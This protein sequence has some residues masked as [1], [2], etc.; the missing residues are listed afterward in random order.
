MKYTISATMRS[1]Q[2]GTPAAAEVKRQLANGPLHE[3][4]VIDTA[5]RGALKMYL[6]EIEPENLFGVLTGLTGT[7]EE[8][9]AV[10]IDQAQ[11]HGEDSILGEYYKVDIT[12]IDESGNF[13]GTI[14][15]GM[16]VP[17]V[18]DT[19]PAMQDIPAA[20]VTAPATSVEAFEKYKLPNDI[21][22]MLG[23]I[24]ADGRATVQDMVDR[25]EY[26]SIQKWGKN[27]L[28]KN[29]LA[30]RKIFG[31]P[32][33]CNHNE[34]CEKPKKLWVDI[35]EYKENQIG[36]IGQGL[37]AAL[38]GYGVML[39][40]PK[41]TGKG[42]YVNTM[43]WLLGVPQYSFMFSEQTS[44]QDVFGS[45]TTDNTASDKLAAMPSSDVAKALI[46]KET[47]RQEDL[48]LMAEFEKLKAEASSMHIKME[49]GQII[50]WVRDGGIYFAD[51]A[52]M[53]AAN[54]FSSIFHRVLD[55]SREVQVPGEGAVK[56]P[57]DAY[58]FGAMNEGY[59]GTADMNEATKSRFK[60]LNFGQPNSVTDVLREAV[61][62][63]LIKFGVQCPEPILEM[64][65]KFY[66]TIKSMADDET[67][68]T[69]ALNTRGLV[70][71]IVEFVT[72]GGVGSLKD[73]VLDNVAYGCP[74]DERDDIARIIQMAFK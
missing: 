54:T 47:K 56:L 62:K 64:A 52:N 53:S 25:L 42:V 44:L 11:L 51:E 7:D 28:I 4:V 71:S 29:H 13:T 15:I 33:F 72:F 45:Q 35:Y 23:K 26:L 37:Q 36:L 8:G 40:G 9:N 27:T 32:R 63:E 18:E 70:R 65:N 57:E 50:K 38:L 6:D 59:E 60:F 73:Y 34:P 17:K 20:E 10:A 24:V 68:G 5:G 69:Q 16:E 61:N 43:C 1:A 31:N 3:R 46:A 66:M 30:L 55:D 39:V 12:A 41:A 48:L 49:E 2:A 14:E 58:F 67:I 74:P 22:A 21:L 19:V